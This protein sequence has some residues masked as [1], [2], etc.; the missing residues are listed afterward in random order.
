M[1]DQLGRRFFLDPDS[2]TQRRYEALRAYFVERQPVTEIAANW[3]YKPASL[4]AMV[5]A[6]RSQ[7]RDG[8]VPP[9]SSPTAAV[10]LPPRSTAK[11][12][13]APTYPPS[14]TGGFWI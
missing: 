6:F 2:T 14:P 13:T 8:R 1:D 12:V 10:G 7:C 11:T 9:F 5:S 3:G 4:N